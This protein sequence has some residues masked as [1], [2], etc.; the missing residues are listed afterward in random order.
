M[1]KVV[2]KMN[3]RDATLFRAGGEPSQNL[4]S[5]IG[6]YGMYAGYLISGNLGLSTR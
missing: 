3:S 6:S 2:K 1:E 5:L 4:G